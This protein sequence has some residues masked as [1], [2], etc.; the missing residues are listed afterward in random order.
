MLNSTIVSR[1]IYLVILANVY[2]VETSEI[3]WSRCVTSELC[4]SVV[5]FTWNKTSTTAVQL[6]RQF[7]PQSCHNET[8]PGVNNE[9]IDA[10][11]FP[12]SCEVPQC[13]I[14]GTC[15]PGVSKDELRLVGSLATDKGDEEQR[16]LHCR[17]SG[18][19]YLF[20]RSCPRNY[21]NETAR[22]MCQTDRPG[23]MSIL[24]ANTRVS[25]AR[26]G[27]GYYNKYCA[28]CNNVLEFE[29]WLI[30]I[31][32]FHYLDV[33]QAVTES[34]LIEM[35]LQPDS[36]CLVREKPPSDH[37]YSCDVLWFRNVIDSCNTSGQWP[38]YDPEIEYNCLHQFEKIT[39]RIL[40]GLTVYKNVFCALCNSAGLPCGI[41]MRVEH[42]NSFPK[43]PFKLILNPQQLLQQEMKIKNVDHSDIQRQ[44]PLAHCPTILCS[45]GKII[46]HNKCISPMTKI[47]GLGY[48]FKL[49]FEY[50]NLYTHNVSAITNLTTVFKDLL[51]SWDYWIK[52]L[53]DQW[54]NSHSILVA[55]RADSIEL[56]EYCVLNSSDQ[57]MLP[58]NLTPSMFYKTI[59]AGSLY[60]A[61]VYF[62]ANDSYGRDD[63]EI[64]LTRVLTPGD[65]QLNFVG[66]SMMLRHLSN[67]LSEYDIQCEEENTFCRSSEA[68]HSDQKRNYILRSDK[69]KFI[70]VSPFLTCPHIILN[71]S[72]FTVEP[73]DSG[74]PWRKQIKLKSEG[75][76]L[77]FS[78]YRDLT[79]IEITKNN[80]L[81][82]CVD[83]FKV[84]L[85]QSMESS[86]F[87]MTFV[88]QY[89]LTL[90]CLSV[91]MLSLVVIITT[92]LAFPVLRN[93]AGLHN[94][95][96]S[97]SLLVSQALLLASSHVHDPSV[98]CAVLG[99]VT[100]FSW[101]NMFCWSI[102]CCHHV[103]SIFN[104]KSRAAHVTSQQIKSV[105]IFRTVLSLLVP[106][107]IVAA[108]II[109][110]YLLSG[111]QSMG[112]GSVI[113][114]LN[115]TNFILYSFVVPLLCALLTNAFFF[116]SSVYQVCKLRNLQSDVSF[117]SEKRRQ[118]CVYIKLSTMTGLF[119]GVAILSEV[120]D[121]DALRFVT[122]VLNGLQGLFLFI[123][124][125]CNRRVLT[126]YRQ[127][128]DQLVTPPATDT[129]AVDLQ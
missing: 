43:L 22:E 88:M 4:H 83:I 16:K 45:E 38:N 92:Y 95:F 29:S 42:G 55:V 8:E 82:L 51:D 62:V 34:D 77:H 119:W 2:V 69:E 115:S 15:C 106:G 7:C 21:T 36:N 94:I 93:V 101:L 20:V 104:S 85:N 124:Y 105:M 54:S 40:V 87:T 28:L 78:G 9:C 68:S 91:S 86:Q 3:N 25:D 44:C 125:I 5:G 13:E 27:V 48:R 71:E 108:V 67:D 24:E 112:Y 63:V 103:Y 102:F 37:Y 53:L 114:Y 50:Q 17:Q 32:C 127:W 31:D 23:M 1:L 122:V 96:L 52:G 99:V 47:S 66:M 81:K 107:S 120:L 129:S 116:L 97:S 26:T 56:T 121:S 75:T 100:H 65:I 39:S 98:L 123:S 57:L 70:S 84:N 35:S 18:Q 64:Y 59:L 10:E 113:C 30:S 74:D 111:G 90:F 73:L 14:Y 60:Y 33:Y 19:G 61:N 128:F 89:L 109:S 41:E 46:Y 118:M 72:Y 49:L 58:G 126:L 12:C 110:D 117:K 6:N 11:C 80:T 76:T 79:R